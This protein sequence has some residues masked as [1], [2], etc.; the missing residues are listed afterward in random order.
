MHHPPYTAG[1]T[2][3]NSRSILDTLVPLFQRAGVQV[4]FSGHEHN[5]QHAHVDGIHYF[6]TGAGS[7]V[8]LDA[9]TRFAE[10]HTVAW[11]AA[12]HFLLIEI[13]RAQMTIR[14]I[15]ELVRGSPLSEVALRD[16]A[17]QP[18]TAP[19]VIASTG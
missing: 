11:A 3:H 1:P 18:V 7:K 10:A 15:A 6:I 13:N 19:I 17:H 14:P 5:F 4:V 8:T 16:A 2:H 12:G 9:P